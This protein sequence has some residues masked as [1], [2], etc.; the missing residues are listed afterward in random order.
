MRLTNEFLPRLFALALTTPLAACGVM[1]GGERPASGLSASGEGVRSLASTGP[2]ADYP[3]VIGDPYTVDG[4]EY[5]PADTWNYDEV[6]YAALDAGT[7]GVTAAHRT[8]P[9]PSYVEVTALESGKT[10]LVRVE[11]RGPMSGPSLT[12]LSTDALDQIGAKDG[13]AVRVRRVNP[14]E[15]ERAA[16]RAGERAPVRLDTP[17]S[18]LVVL[19]RKLPESGSASLAMAKQPAP[20]PVEAAIEAALGDDT[21]EDAPEAAP[22]IASALPVDAEE[23]QPDL[24]SV[25]PLAATPEPEGSQES[26][27]EPAE[28]AKE[29]VIQAAAFSS[30]ANAKRAAEALGGF[31]VPGGKYFRVQTGPFTSRGQADAALA[32]VKAAGYSDAR[33]ANAG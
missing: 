25:A 3:V 27:A 28:A 1:G 8:L 13:D 21:A 12:A 18:L 20:A 24:A 22:A 5:V 10:A 2:E 19:K 15:I 11:R 31:V 14:P 30:E 9:L 26:A 7:G 6:G 16:L 17:Q 29:L 4:V 23:S 33:V 32:K